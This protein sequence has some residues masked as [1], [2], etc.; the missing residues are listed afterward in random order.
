[1]ANLTPDKIR[2]FI[3]PFQNQSMANL[4]PDHS[5]ITQGTGRAGVPTGEGND[6]IVTASGKLTDSIDI[7]TFR[8]GHL[9]SQP[10][11]GW[12]RTKDPDY[13]G[14]DQ[15]NI[16]TDLNIFINSAGSTSVNYIPSDAIQLSH[17]SIMMVYE[18]DDVTH[19]TIFV[20]IRS[21]TSKEITS[22]EINSLKISALGS[23][24]QYPALCMLPDES[25]IC[26]YWMNDTHSDLAQIQVSRSTDNGANWTVISSRAIK[27]DIDTSGTFGA[28]TAG[29]D[30]STISMAANSH[31][32]LL[33][34]GI[35]AHNTSLA[36]ASIVQQ[37][38]STAEGTFFDL[39]SQSGV[40][41]N[42]ADP[43][44]VSYN[45][46]FIISWIDS[47]DTIGFTRLPNAFEDIQE[48]LTVMA[49]DNK[50]VSRIVARLDGNRWVDHNR[51]MWID[52]DGRMYCG[53]VMDNDGTGTY[54][55]QFLEM[56][57]SDL[58]GLTF[59]KYGADWLPFGQVA[60]GTGGQLSILTSSKKGI[61]NIVGAP[62]VGG[63]EI[64]CKWGSG[65]TNV[66]E[67][68]IYRL[69]MGGWGTVNYPALI[70]YPQDQN[71]AYNTE[72]WIPIDLPTE[73][74]VWT[75]VTA[76]AAT[77]TLA[78]TL[79]I[80]GPTS[81]DT[82]TF[83]KTISDKTGGCIVHAKM[84]CLDDG[85]ELTSGIQI[86]IAESASANT[87]MARVLL[88]TDTI[89]LIDQHDVSNSATGTGLSSG[90][91]EL[92]LWVDNKTNKVKLFYCNCEQFSKQNP[93]TFSKLELTL[94]TDPD[95]TERITWGMLQ[96]SAGNVES[97]FFYVSYAI[98]AA[99][100][101]GID[102]IYP[103]QYPSQGYNVAINQNLKIS[104]KGGP[105]R[106]NDQYLID[107]R[108]D[109]PIDRILYNVSPSKEVKWMSDSV[110][111][112]DATAVTEQKIAWL[113]DTDLVGDE[114]SR[115][116]TDTWGIHLANINFLDLK[117]EVY[118]S[119]SWTSIG[120]TYKNA[121][122]SVN[123]TGGSFNFDR[124]GNAIVCSD[125]TGG[126]LHFNEAEGWEI[127]LDDGAGQT[128][129]RR[130]MHNS[131]GVLGTGTAKNAVIRI[132]SPKTTDPT[133]G[134]A[135]LIPN[136]LTILYTT[137]RR[138]FAAFR[139]TIT[140]QKTSS[141]RFEI[142]NM[143]MGPLIVPAYQ[144]SRGRT[145]AFEADVSEDVLT[146]GVMYS[147]KNG[148]GGRVVR[149]AW[150][151][152]VDVSELYNATSDPDYYNV[153]DGAA[154]PVAAVGSAPTTAL[155]MVNYLNGSTHPIVY[156][157]NIPTDY[158][159]HWYQWILVINDYHDHVM[160]TMGNDAQIENVVGDES[161]G[162][163]SGEVFRVSTIVLR[164][165]R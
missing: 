75:Q 116:L 161:T 145:I 141:G 83:Y 136:S 32:V 157:P 97:E 40:S 107:P 35:S 93:R 29:Y 155:G 81:G 15:P 152:G 1:M 112:P 147:R 37:Y 100:G 58:K 5:T 102:S 16:I 28:G 133:S 17:N 156:L 72:D 121:W 160:C 46:A 18:K 129:Q 163:G 106:E 22:Y 123:G 101:L 158:S 154:Y 117:V 132:Q 6:L 43:R 49:L 3:V 86:Q 24:R 109:T 20:A 31:S 26:A 150:T 21:Y 82:L 159:E 65:T 64:F 44:V 164:E 94:T 19:N 10:G 33:F 153:N 8:G 56:W 134:T 14:C 25:I 61:D 90:E 140:S 127:F 139:I 87:I 9:I 52:Q 51:S 111:D 138:D 122:R 126:Y 45:E 57:F 105:A 91:H 131:G 79:T 34:A 95:S 38:A 108:Y 125:A 143:I 84:K 7:K 50:T 59:D 148:S 98:G 11:F 27:D 13:N 30:L 128:V 47:P 76:S 70:S 103:K 113:L 124:I 135:Y 119:G 130:V 162:G 80:D 144:Y 118:E 23:I 42:Y 4:W 96:N 73:G 99:T 110:A 115:P 149:I 92:L 39:I 89:K 55:P 36:N 63:Q 142:G 66:Y 60:G 146:N 48:R 74:S 71:T 41:V 85:S 68:S 12:K 78:D 53:H 151:E 67:R 137:V 104:T 165:T 2:G 88:G 114:D 54:Q 120:S 62:G 77:V 69:T